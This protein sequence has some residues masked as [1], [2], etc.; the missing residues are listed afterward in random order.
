MESRAHLKRESDQFAL[1][2]QHKLTHLR[3]REPDDQQAENSVRVV[4]RGPLLSNSE[5]GRLPAVDGIPEHALHVE[6]DPQR[7]A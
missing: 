6:Q 1:C 2:L 7:D 5:R 3:K 4:L